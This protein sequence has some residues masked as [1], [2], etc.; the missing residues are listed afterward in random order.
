[1]G[2]E[3]NKLGAVL[4][5]LQSMLRLEKKFPL[6][7]ATVSNYITN[8]RGL[9]QWGGGLNRESFVIFYSRNS[10]G[11]PTRKIGNVCSMADIIKKLEC[12]ITP[13]IIG[14]FLSLGTCVVSNLL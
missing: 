1:M 7:T 12:E 11:K 8:P 4:K 14:V 2:Q 10:T 3:A 5:N 9:G 13:D 6:N